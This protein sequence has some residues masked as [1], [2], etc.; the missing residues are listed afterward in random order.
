MTST[1]WRRSAMESYPK[2]IRSTMPDGEEGVVFNLRDKLHNERPA[3]DMASSIHHSIC[4]T[5]YD[6]NP[7]YGFWAL[8]NLW[9]LTEDNQATGIVFEVPESPVG[10]GPVD[11]PAVATKSVTPPLGWWTRGRP[12]A[13]DRTSG[14]RQMQLYID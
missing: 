14:G 4:W 11:L 3:W 10:D 9:T 6:D 1:A 2:V 13:G 8:A 7:E 5:P 12:W